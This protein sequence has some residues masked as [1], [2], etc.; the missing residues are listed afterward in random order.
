MKIEFIKNKFFYDQLK[1][2][3]WILV[4]E[5][6]SI[7]SSY[8][9]NN[10]FF[11]YTYKN[12][13]E[14]YNIYF[15]I[16]YINSGLVKYI[17]NIIYK[18]FFLLSLSVDKIKYFFIKY[19]IYVLD[20]VFSIFEKKKN[21]LNLN[22]FFFFQKLKIHTN[23]IKI[24]SLNS[25]FFFNLIKNNEFNDLNEKFNFHLNNVESNSNYSNFIEEEI[26]N[27]CIFGEDIIKKNLICTEKL[28][29]DDHL[30]EY[31]EDLCFF[32][33]FDDVNCNSVKLNFFSIDINKCFKDFTF[34]NFWSFNCIGLIY[35]NNNIVSI[36]NKN[37]FL[38]LNFFLLYLRRFIDYYNFVIDNNLFLL[39]KIIN[40]SKVEIY[41]YCYITNNSFINFNFNILCIINSVFFIFRNL[42]KEI[43]LY[44]YK[45]N[46]EFFSKN[47]YKYLNI[48]V[49]GVI[50]KLFF[51]L[52]IY[53]DD[54]NN[55]NSKLLMKLKN[56][57]S[58]YINNDKLIN[59]FDLYTYKYMGNT[60]KNLFFINDSKD[61]I[62]LS[63]RKLLYMVEN[64]KCLY[65]S[66]FLFNNK[67]N[68]L[69]KHFLLFI[70]LYIYK[71]SKN[72]SFNEKYK[73][74]NFHFNEN[75]DKDY[76]KLLVRQSIVRKINNNNLGLISNSIGMDNKIL[77]NYKKGKFLKWF[78]IF[79]IK[80]FN[81]KVISDDIIG[82]INNL[83]F[84]YNLS[85]YYYY[86]FNKLSYMNNKIFSF[87]GKVG[88]NR[89]FYSSN[90]EF[91]KV[92]KFFGFINLIAYNDDDVINF[93]NLKKYNNIIDNI[94]FKIKYKKLNSL[95]N[96]RLLYLNKIISYIYNI[97]I[98]NT[99][100]S[101]SLSFDVVFKL[102]L[103]LFLRY[104][105]IK[106]DV[107]KKNFFSVKIKFSFL[108]KRKYL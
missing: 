73:N 38:K 76:T 100:N 12:G 45:V 102:R 57:C 52:N 21:N 97:Y 30:Y 9:I 103:L 37:I 20:T 5:L 65:K 4:E 90:L 36:K 35:L 49:Y 13:R 3:L 25:L 61:K 47:Y 2:L 56:C 89:L 82:Y 32:S 69:Y 64:K 83:Y 72:L 92:K 74:F 77:Y 40:F 10:K 84:N 41:N 101:V 23:A 46:N 62:V 86:L 70:I 17:Y 60:M 87:F 54:K 50:Q 59:V 34:L 11:F 58:A 85:F 29:D 28:S 106:R 33:S 31:D 24:K 104:S 43:F 51:N 7:Y 53:N 18:F 39:K 68:D 79:F 91:I 6:V 108:M 19:I 107:K 88:F 22:Y 78:F 55:V 44:F 80:Y 67:N 96:K 27:N 14:I 75:E 63:S 66:L 71:W 26:N 93:F 105:Y 1:S 81:S 95:I 48:Y 94:F 15:Y 16:N 99:I 98:Y 42:V 8:Y